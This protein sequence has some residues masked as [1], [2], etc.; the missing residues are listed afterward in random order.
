MIDV[1]V[2]WGVWSEELEGILMNNQD[3]FII[4]PDSSSNS[5]SK[6]FDVD[7]AKLLKPFDTI[8]R[9]KFG[10]QI[11]IIQ[12]DDY[13][14]SQQL[15][16]RDGI[17]SFMSMIHI[18]ED[19]LHKTKDRVSIG[20]MLREQLKNLSPSKELIIIDSYVFKTRKD[21]E[22]KDHFKFFTDIFSPTISNIK[23]L[24]FITSPKYNGANYDFFKKSL[25]E[26]NPEL[27]VV[28][29]TTEDFHDRFWIIDRTKGLVI[30]TSINGIGNKY[31]LWD[32]LCDKDI[33]YLLKIL[34][35]LRLL[36]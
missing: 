17:T 14:K 8:L 32:I 15:I 10:L 20:D 7:I 35:E 26:L 36:D 31:A 24:K 3:A 34:M 30:G 5:S 28:C 19:I 25:T 21:E 6:G 18:Q 9:E 29:N 23:D 22:L 1:V 2:E 16:K 33:K 12:R 13:V 27:T 4:V 11:K